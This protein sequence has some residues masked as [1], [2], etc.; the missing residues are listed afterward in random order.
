MRKESVADEPRTAGDLPI[1][2]EDRYSKPAPA[3]TPS[4][5]AVLS[6]FEQPYSCVDAT[7][8]IVQQ[9]E[10]CWTGRFWVLVTPGRHELQLHDG[11]AVTDGGRIW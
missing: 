6:I 8:V 4:N 2:T 1:T 9:I 11:R 5:P 7:G 3:V 10:K